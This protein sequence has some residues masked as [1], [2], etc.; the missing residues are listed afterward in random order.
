VAILG[1]SLIIA[2]GVITP[3]Q[4]VLGAIQG[5]EVVKPD[6]TK[7]TIIGI[8]C[9]IL[10]LLFVIQPLGVARIGGVFAPVIII[11]LFLNLSFGIFV[12][13]VT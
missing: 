13:N 1:V 11:W 3:A 2:D 12:R 4:S 7:G 10:V 8:T 5:L 6:I 9:A